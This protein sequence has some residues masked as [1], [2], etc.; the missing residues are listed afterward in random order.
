M[1]LVFIKK[2]KPINRK[3]H[4]LRAVYGELSMQLM[5]FYEISSNSDNYGQWHTENIES[6]RLNWQSIK[7]INANGGERRYLGDGIGSIDWELSQ[8]SPL[9]SSS[10]WRTLTLMSLVCPSSVRPPIMRFSLNGKRKPPE[11]ST[12]MEQRTLRDRR[13]LRKLEVVV[14]Y[15]TI[16]F[17]LGKYRQIRQGVIRKQQCHGPSL[18]GVRQGP[19]SWCCS[20]P[21]DPTVLTYTA[22]S[23]RAQC[24]DKMEGGN[25]VAC[26]V[27]AYS[28]GEKWRK[29]LIFGHLESRIAVRARGQF[30][31]FSGLSSTSN[32]WPY[33]GLVRSDFK[34]L[35]SPHK[36]AQI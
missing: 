2:T 22:Q 18:G 6:Y 24:D 16:H 3:P 31:I 23:Y 25:G 32:Y 15:S 33:E 19:V 11:V 28:S 13:C 12:I 9:L 20:E 26:R 5:F 17:Q 1:L 34:F 29:E 8:L 14:K 36:W 4:F 30:L 7:R 27:L 10:T 21:R 35:F